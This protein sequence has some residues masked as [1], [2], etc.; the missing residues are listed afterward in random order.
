MTRI[1]IVT[2]SP[3]A[4]RT[5]V[6]TITN[7]DADLIVGLESSSE[8]VVLCPRA[9]WATA[10]SIA[11]YTAIFTFVFLIATPRRRLEGPTQILHKVTRRILE[12]K[13]PIAVA[14]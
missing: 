5:S 4:D 12:C 2:S 1:K 8:E 14:P 6:G 7:V 10:T 9:T 13:Y 3:D 11:K